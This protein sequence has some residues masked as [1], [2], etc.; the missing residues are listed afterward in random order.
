MLNITP[1]NFFYLTIAYTVVVI[2]FGF[3]LAQSSIVFFSLLFGLLPA[4]SVS[5][6]YLFP[7]IS[8]YRNYFFWVAPVIVM[9]GFWLS[10]L[11]FK[12]NFVENKNQLQQITG[13]IPAT[14][15]E[16]KSRRYA[17]SYVK[18]ADTA[19]HCSDSIYDD[20][21]K[22]YPYK[23]QTATVWYQPNMRVGNLAYEIVVNN[24]P[25]YRF[26][27]QKALFLQEKKVKVHEWLWTFILLGF[28]SILLGFLERKV[29]N[30]KP[31]ISKEE[32]EIIKKYQI[33]QYEK[34]GLLKYVGVMIFMLM[35]TVGF[36]R[37]FFEYAKNN[38]GSVISWSIFTLIAF[39]L[40]CVCAKSKKKTINESEIKK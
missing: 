33:V 13:V 8:P 6:S 36:G 3:W 11:D 25:I 22:I 34:I 27:M 15:T 17:T 39:Y 9:V 2:I 40:M 16:I 28:P 20:C 29:I 19:I 5:F 1:K 32:F 31:K 30:T 12:N 18:I 38:H 10:G 7:Q 21:A 4:L 37:S 35:A 24:E 23:G 14:N 26:D